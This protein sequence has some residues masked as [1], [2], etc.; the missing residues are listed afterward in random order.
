[1]LIDKISRGV[2]VNYENEPTHLRSLGEIKSWKF[3]IHQGPEKKKQKTEHR[4]SWTY[5]RLIV[6]FRHVHLG[7]VWYCGCG[8]GWSSKNRVS[9]K[10]F[11]TV[12]QKKQ[13]IVWL[14]LWL[15][16]RLKKK[17]FWCLVSKLYKLL[18]TCEIT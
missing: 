13:L 15:S 11:F 2:L 5:E 9:K 17:Q 16:W 1:M 14:K 4:R 7:L 8:Y 10:A 3:R 6:I 12:V 18:L